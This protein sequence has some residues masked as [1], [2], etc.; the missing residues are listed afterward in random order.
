MLPEEDRM[1]T[2]SESGRAILLA[3]QE[4]LN[5]LQK[6]KANNLPDPSARE[7]VST[8]ARDRNGDPFRAAI[9]DL[10]AAKIVEA[11]PDWKIRLNAGAPAR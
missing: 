1:A 4:I 7:I 8:L 9:T 11:T 3:R 6:I 10:I 2:L 5:H